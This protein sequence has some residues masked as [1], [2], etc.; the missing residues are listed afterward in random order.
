M[1]M[2]KIKN[3]FFFQD[4]TVIRTLSESVITL[5]TL[6]KCEPKALRK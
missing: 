6:K 4:V 3:D 5:K 2:K 1:S